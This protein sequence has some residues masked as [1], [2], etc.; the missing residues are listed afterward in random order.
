MR[1]L[2]VSL[3]GSKHPPYVVARHDDMLTGIYKVRMENGSLYVDPI[4]KHAIHIKPRETL[5]RL[6]PDTARWIDTCRRIYAQR[7]AKH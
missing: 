5:F 6:E 2:S 4:D 3:N 7:L 1:Y